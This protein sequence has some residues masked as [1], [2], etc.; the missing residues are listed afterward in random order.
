MSQNLIFPVGKCTKKPS[1]FQKSF[2]SSS[3]GTGG[4]TESWVKRRGETVGAKQEG[5]KGG[6]KRSSPK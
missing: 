3:S 6:A 2:N 1:Q 4:E 5:R